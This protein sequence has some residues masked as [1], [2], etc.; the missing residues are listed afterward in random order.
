MRHPLLAAFG[1]AFAIALPGT[2]PAQTPPPALTGLVSSADEKAMEGVLV[3]ATRT[4][5]TITTTVVTGA[6]GRFSFPAGRL[7]PGPSQL[8]VR[9]VGYQLDTPK[10]VDVPD[11][12]TATQD[13]KL[14]KTDDLAAQLSNVEWLDSIP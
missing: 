14:G 2:A 9:A 13:L 1:V 7:G 8:A 10:T 11:H 4:G 3:S 12:A 5:S 6:D